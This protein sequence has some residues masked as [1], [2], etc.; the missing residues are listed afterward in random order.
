MTCTRTSYNSI[1]FIVGLHDQPVQIP[2]DATELVGVFIPSD[3][4]SATETQFPPPSPSPPATAFELDWARSPSRLPSE[5][6]IDGKS[7]SAG[8]CE[9]TC[10]D[11]VI[12]GKVVEATLPT[13]LFVTFFIC[14]C[15]STIT[16][17]RRIYEMYV[18]DVQDP[19]SA[20]ALP[21]TPDGLHL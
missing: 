14:R 11:L 19:C 2:I 13:I 21:V 5:Q 4:M 18:R 3:S 15:W 12:I 7:L 6:A 20:K 17:K 1:F 8:P 10:M 16:R 9:V